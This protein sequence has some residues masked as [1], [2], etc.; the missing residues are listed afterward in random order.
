MKAQLL[1][2]SQG[3]KTFA[4]VFAAGDEAI[5]GLTAFAKDKGL[6]ASHFTA[7]GQGEIILGCPERSTL[8]VRL[9]GN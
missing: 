5:A 6:A 8:G 2:D 9:R 4:V 7:I 3:E 1:H